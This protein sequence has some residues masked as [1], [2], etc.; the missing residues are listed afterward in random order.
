MPAAGEPALSD[1]LQ[2]L[3]S[4]TDA[5]LLATLQ[6]RH[7]AR[8]CYTYSGP[9]V[10][11]SVNPY[12]WSASLPLYTD[13]MREQYGAAP[14]GDLC[15]GR[16]SLPPHLYAVAE[17]A[18]RRRACPGYTQSLLVGGESGAGKT[19]AVKILLKYLCEQ[20][21][22]LSLGGAVPGASAAV[23]GSTIV[24]RLI[25][26]NPLL[27]AFGNAKTALNHNSSRFG[28]LITL[29]FAPPP[30]NAGDAALHAPISGGVLSSYLLEKVRVVQHAAGE[31][32]FHVFYQV[33]GRE[34]KERASARRALGCLLVPRIRAEAGLLLLPRSLL[35][36]IPSTDYLFAL[37][38]RPPTHSSCTILPRLGPSR[39]SF[40]DAQRHWRGGGGAPSADRDDLDHNLRHDRHAPCIREGRQERQRRRQQRQEQQQRW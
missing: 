10:I 37:C 24:Q 28:K 2:S 31:A 4:L 19:E 25:E 3:S 22:A 7:K 11:V 16:R 5:A 1:D 40:S 21:S 14:E 35:P 27:E 23:G 15:G 18:R 17:Q 30:P 13:A 32:S 8:H 12:D 9:R 38:A 33:R 20:Q 36:A 6:A 26:L 34:R 39:S 29:H